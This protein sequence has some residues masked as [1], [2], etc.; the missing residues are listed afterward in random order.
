LTPDYRVDICLGSSPSA[1]NPDLEIENILHADIA[2]HVAHVQSS[3]TGLGSTDGF[4]CEVVHRVRPA[5]DMPGADDAREHVHIDRD[6]NIKPTD[7][8]EGNIKCFVSWLRVRLLVIRR[9][10]TSRPLIVIKSIGG[11]PRGCSPTYSIYW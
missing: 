11:S 6:G 1:N 4:K 3:V 2:L 10:L 7:D 8:W 9:Y 5:H